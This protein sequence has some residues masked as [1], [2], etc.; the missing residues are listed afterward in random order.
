[1]RSCGHS[2]SNSRNST[3]N[4]AQSLL[5]ECAR[6]ACLF[7]NSFRTFGAGKQFRRP[8]LSARSCAKFLPTR[9]VFRVSRHRMERIF[10]KNS[11]FVGK[12]S[13]V[14]INCSIASTGL[15]DT[16]LRRSMVIPSIA[17]GGNNFSS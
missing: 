10:S 6:K 17:S 9:R 14:R 1:M 2:K 5:R 3:R 7:W 13:S 4:P 16:K 11:T 15:N 8:N 12:R